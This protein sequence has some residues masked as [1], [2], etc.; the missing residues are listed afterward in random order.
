M[1]K[2]KTTTKKKKKWSLYAWIAMF[3]TGS[4]GGGGFMLKD[5]PMVANLVHSVFGD[6]PTDQPVGQ[7]VAGRL[8]QEV[9][10]RIP[11]R[12]EIKVNELE[13]GAEA[14][15]GKKGPSLAV[16]VKRVDADG[17]STVVWESPSQTAKRDV[18]GD[19]W[20]TD[21]KAEPFRVDWKPG[22][23]VVVEVVQARGLLESTTFVMN[24]PA[25]DTFPLTSG[26]H[27]LKMAGVDTPSGKNKITLQAT[28]L[29]SLKA[30]ATAQLIDRIP[31]KR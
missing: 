31:V 7:V 19:P 8:K 24:E 16:R 9:S 11:G 21:W 22:E 30:D 4:G 27:V 14:A 29:G 10:N 18:A 6:V 20:K 28:R 2:R 25:K 23:Q 26:T 3:L 5:H 15:K 17:K 1:A 13:I 12:F